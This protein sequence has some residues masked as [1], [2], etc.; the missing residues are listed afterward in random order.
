M[1]LRPRQ[2]GT[3]LSRRRPHG[4]GAAGP[5]L[6][7]LGSVSAALTPGRRHECPPPPHRGRRRPRAPR[8]PAP[9]DMAALRH[10][11]GRGARPRRRPGPLPRPG[12]RLRRGQRRQAARRTGVA[13]G[14]AAE[15]RE[16]RA[17]ARAGQSR[18]EGASPSLLLGFGG[19]SVLTI[20]FFSFF[21]LVSQG[22][23]VFP[24]PFPELSFTV[25]QLVRE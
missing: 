12:L 14:G 24:F 22:C 11:P 7:P 20:F 5:P 15:R 10:R 23:P 18:G 19:A 13:G 1:S 9:P 6:P 21:C 17:A 16:A 8:R 2:P 25:L 3:A 4:K